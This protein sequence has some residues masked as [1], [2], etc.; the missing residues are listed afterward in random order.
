MVGK[1]GRKRV[2]LFLA[3]MYPAWRKVGVLDVGFAFSIVIRDQ[4]CLSG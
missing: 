2:L 3:D 1:W 4:A